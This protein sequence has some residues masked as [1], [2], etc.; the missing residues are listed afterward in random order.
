MAVTVGD[1]N[2]I[3]LA[4]P[5]LG[6]SSNMG[7]Y[8]VIEI[9]A[10]E[11]TDMAIRDAIDEAA[12]SP[13]DDLIVIRTT[14]TNNTIPLTGGQL[15]ININ[16]ATHGSITIVSLGDVP[17]TIDA[18]ELSRIM[19]IGNTSTVALGGLTIANGNDY[20]GGGIYNYGNLTIANSIITGNHMPDDHGGNGGGIYNEYGTLTVFHSTFTDN[21]AGWCCMDGGGIYNDHGTV[22]VTN[23]TFTGNTAGGYGHGGGIYND[24]ATLTVINSTFTQNYAGDNGGGI[25]NSSGSSLTVI[26]STFTENST[27]GGGGGICNYYGT[28][29]L[30]HSTFSGNTAN[31]GGGIYACGGTATVN[32]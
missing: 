19:S 15:S 6:L 17:L 9:T 14:V 26:N 16:A 2:A 27:D 25:Y 31:Y 13:G 22:T 11:L 29:S 12:L 1:F 8:H 23:S 28:L 21:A 3:R 18:N 10:A 20:Y 4:Y 7:D 30:T 24:Q 5:D 32:N